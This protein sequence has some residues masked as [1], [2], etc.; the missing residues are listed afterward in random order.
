VIAPPQKWRSAKPNALPAGI[1]CSGRSRCGWPPR[2]RWR[3]PS[4]KRR[5]GCARPKRFAPRRLSRIASACRGLL[6][7]GR[8]DAALAR[9]L[10]RLGVTAREAEV[11]GLAG[12]RLSNK[13]IAGQLYLSPRTAEKHVAS[14]LL[15][16]G[17]AGR[18]ALGWLAR[19]R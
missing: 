4:G 17:A 7:P 16:T 13:D 1:C 3:T 5:G 19:Q 10:L 9:D 12:E 14:L 6:A 2:P 18:A 8:D 15:K 11:L